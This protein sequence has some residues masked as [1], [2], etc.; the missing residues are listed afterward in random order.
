MPNFNLFAYS[1]GQMSGGQEQLG[2]FLVHKGQKGQKDRGCWQVARVLLGVE[3]QWRRLEPE[4]A[5]SAKGTSGK[6]RRTDR[7]QACMNI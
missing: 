1:V 2:S 5:V 4:V 3:G 7:R 6:L